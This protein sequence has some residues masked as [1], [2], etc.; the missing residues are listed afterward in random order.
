MVSCKELV[1]QLGSGSPADQHQ[2]VAAL[3]ALSLTRRNWLSAVG[4]ISRLVELL[5]SASTTAPQARTIRCLLER[6][7]DCREGEGALAAPYGVIAPLVSLLL[8]HDEA[9]GQ[10][11]VALTFSNLAM[12]I[13]NRDMIVEAGA[14]VPSSSCWDPAQWRF[15]NQQRELWPTS[16]KGAA[17]ALRSSQPVS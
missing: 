3:S 13:S 12:T 17:P 15:S 11:L 2:A 14:I 4:A 7:S 9:D 16:Q 1:R 5:H 10:R 8:C 6:I